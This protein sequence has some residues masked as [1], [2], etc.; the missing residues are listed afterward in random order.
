MWAAAT[1]NY[2]PIFYPVNSNQMVSWSSVLCFNSLVLRGETSGGNLYTSNLAFQYES[3]HRTKVAIILHPYRVGKSD[4]VTLINIS[5][6]K[7]PVKT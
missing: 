7:T 2:L 6:V 4:A 5:N 3:E 1:K